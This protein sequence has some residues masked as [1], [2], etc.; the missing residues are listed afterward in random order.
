M[1][2]GENCGFD[3]IKHIEKSLTKYRPVST[4]LTG[5]RQQGE[6]S[7][8]PEVSFAPEAAIVS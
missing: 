6:Q 3:V 2:A 7:L 1:Q 5:V 4:P 8:F